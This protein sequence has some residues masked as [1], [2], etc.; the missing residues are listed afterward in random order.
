MYIYGLRD[1]LR[2]GK[3]PPSV[4]CQER[5]LLNIVNVKPILTGA[6]FSPVRA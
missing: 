5:P 4:F 3:N 6:E 1:F 2:L